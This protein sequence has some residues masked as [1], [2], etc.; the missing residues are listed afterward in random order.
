[1]RSGYADGSVDGV[2]HPWLCRPDVFFCLFAGRPRAMAE[3]FF[4]SRQP[5]LQ[6]PFF[7]GIKL[8][9]KKGVDWR[10]FH[11]FSYFFRHTPKI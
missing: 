2:A 3:M 11:I 9:D 10:I 6:L 1:M 8:S 4:L 7:V 5:L